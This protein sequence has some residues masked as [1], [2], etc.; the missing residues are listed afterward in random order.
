MRELRNTAGGR[1]LWRLLNVSN[2]AA[3]CD[4]MSRQ[5]RSPPSWPQEHR[6]FDSSSLSVAMLGAGL[7]GLPRQRQIE[8]A[9]TELSSYCLLRFPPPEDH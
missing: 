5:T 8:E 7:R 3:R 2:K 4:S 9:T 6:A 1:A